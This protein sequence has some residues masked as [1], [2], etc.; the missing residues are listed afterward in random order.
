MGVERKSRGMQREGVGDP[1]TLAYLRPLSNLHP[2]HLKLLQSWE[3]QSLWQLVCREV[4]GCHS[5]TKSVRLAAPSPSNGLPLS[6]RHPSWGWVP[7]RENEAI[8]IPRKGEGGLGPGQAEAK[9]CGWGGRR[10]IEPKAL[11]NA[12]VSLTVLA[13][14]TLLRLAQGFWAELA[15]EISTGPTAHFSGKGGLAGPGVLHGLG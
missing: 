12:C 8:K 13:L 9:G 7:G 5:S 14:G 2:P 6:W 10:K 3:L 1:S 4:G 11:G 15:A